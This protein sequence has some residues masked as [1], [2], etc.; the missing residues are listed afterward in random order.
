MNESFF[1]FSASSAISLSAFCGLGFRG[2]SSVV[3]RQPQLLAAKC[4]GPQGRQALPLRS[5]LGGARGAF[6]C[7]DVSTKLLPHRRKHLLRK[8]MLLA[9]PEAHE[10]RSAQD[11][12]GHSFFDGC[13]DR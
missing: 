5:F 2:W 10:Q 9:R 3:G 13:L 1:L 4:R 12:D 6:P 11:I 8:R 7:L